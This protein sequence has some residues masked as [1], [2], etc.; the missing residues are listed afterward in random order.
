MPPARSGPSG[1]RRD[2][3]TRPRCRK[4]RGAAPPRAAGRG[5]PARTA[6]RVGRHGR[7]VRWELTA[8]GRRLL[9]AEHFTVDVGELMIGQSKRAS[10]IPMTGSTKLISPPDAVIAHVITIKVVA[11]PTPAEAAAVPVAEA[12]PAEAP[13]AGG[14]A[15]DA[16]GGNS[17]RH[18][19]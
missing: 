5:R 14:K 16:G 9:S 19:A 18:P 4:P 13:A 15:G 10:D 3:G 11:E 17:T 8:P 7:R 6:L 12:A 1:C 2:R